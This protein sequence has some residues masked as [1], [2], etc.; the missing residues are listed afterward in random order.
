MGKAGMVHTQWVEQL[1]GRPCV[2]R[3]NS[4]TRKHNKGARWLAGAQRAT[5]TIRMQHAMRC[6]WKFNP[7]KRCC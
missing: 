5:H 2:C 1:R 7:A 3:H 4:R 6:A